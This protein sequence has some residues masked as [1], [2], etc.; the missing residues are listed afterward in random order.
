MAWRPTNYLIEGELDNTTPGKVTGWMRFAGR[1]EKVTFDLTGDFHRDIRG[2]RIYLTGDAREKEPGDEY[3]QGFSQKQTGQ[4]GDITAGLW[5]Y[6]YVKGFCY[7]EWFSQE[8]G[9][10]VLELESDQVQIIGKPLEADK[11]EPIS[12]ERQAAHMAEYMRD[13][14]KMLSQNKRKKSGK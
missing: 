5:P 11:C 12:R 1:R 13:L 14:G 4:A 10:V 3:M 6:D 9:R 8:N 2:A 7:I